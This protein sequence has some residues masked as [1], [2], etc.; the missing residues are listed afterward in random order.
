[1]ARSEES[2]LAFVRKPGTPAMPSFSD[3]GAKDLSDLYAYL[4][5]L[6]P[7]PPAAQSIPLLRGILE[8]IGQARP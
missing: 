5:S 6:H 7:T 2:F 8:Q 4:R 1:M 3:V